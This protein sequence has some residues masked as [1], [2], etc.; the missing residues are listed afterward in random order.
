MPP[1][2]TLIAALIDI[3]YSD[4]IQLI[5]YQ[6]SAYPVSTMQSHQSDALYSNN[7]VCGYTC[8]V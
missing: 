3:L 1:C 5:T 8:T 4:T 2:P 7:S 6:M